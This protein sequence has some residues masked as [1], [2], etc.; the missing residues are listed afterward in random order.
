MTSAGNILQRLW[1]TT[2]H[3]TPDKM[4]SIYSEL[5]GLIRRKG[6]LNDA[7]SNRFLL[8]LL[9]RL[10]LDARWLPPSFIGDILTELL[11]HTQTTTHRGNRIAQC[12]LAAIG[13]DH[14]QD[15]RLLEL[16]HK[17]GHA[18]E[19]L[20]RIYIAYAELD[21]IP[22]EL[23]QTQA[24]ELQHAL[25]HVQRN[26]PQ[27]VRRLRLALQETGHASLLAWPHSS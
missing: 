26:R 19:I 4:Q 27:L 10:E 13:R 24:E 5:L 17:A 20:V 14:Q 15:R 8:L 16:A 22:V 9:D 25:S 3:A 7:S 2:S 1:V 11:E 18:P 23:L 12:S 21:L 6:G